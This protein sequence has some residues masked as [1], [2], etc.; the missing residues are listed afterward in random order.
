VHTERKGGGEGREDRGRKMESD[1][2]RFSGSVTVLAK[3]G[4]PDKRV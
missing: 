3:A 2:T 4:A 1:E